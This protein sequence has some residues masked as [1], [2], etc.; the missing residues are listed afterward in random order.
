MDQSVPLNCGLLD[1]ARC[2]LPEG[3]LVN[4]VYPAAVG[5]RSLSVNRLQSCVFGAFARAL[6]Q[7]TPAAPG[8]GGQPRLQMGRK[9]FLQRHQTRTSTTGTLGTS[10]ALNEATL[11]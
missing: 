9:L 4:P 7:L 11:V 6:P 1:A 5:M 2:V 3:S 8:D 10:P